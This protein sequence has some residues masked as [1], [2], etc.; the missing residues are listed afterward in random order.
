MQAS[1]VSSTLRL[2]KQPLGFTIATLPF[3]GLFINHVHNQQG[4]IDDTFQ[5]RGTSLK[6]R[7]ASTSSMAPR[8]R[9][10]GEKDRDQDVMMWGVMLDLI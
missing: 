8:R 2:V 7:A 1:V 9:E 10:R 3:V 6:E 4:R 5:K